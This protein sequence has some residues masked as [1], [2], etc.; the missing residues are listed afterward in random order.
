M[1]SLRRSGP[2]LTTSPA[3]IRVLLTCRPDPSGPWWPTGRRGVL[4]GAPIPAAH[5]GS[6][7]ELGGKTESRAPGERSP[8]AERRHEGRGLIWVFS[9]PRPLTA[10]GEH[11][12]AVEAEEIKKKL[13][14]PRQRKCSL[15]LPGS[16]ETHNFSFTGYFPPA[17][18]CFHHDPLP[19][20]K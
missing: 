18:S 2:P 10:G 6:P 16:Y 14:G 12:G 15:P 8:E 3:P 5:T 4:T 13:S 11:P 20:G 19:C 7:G 9:S 1:A 17:L